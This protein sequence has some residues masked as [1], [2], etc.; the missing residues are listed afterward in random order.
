MPPKPEPPKFN[1]KDR[2]NWTEIA[3]KPVAEA[4]PV[5]RKALEDE[6]PEVQK[7]AA[8]ALANSGPPAAPAV[9]ELARALA[10][11]RDTE[12][13]RNAAVALALILRPPDGEAARRNPSFLP[14][15]R[16]HAPEAVPALVQCLKPTEPAEVRLY[17]A[18]ALA[19]IHYPAN[20]K[21]LPALLE[22]L[23][24][25]ADPQV[26][27]RCVWALYHVPD[28]KAVNAEKPLLEVL[29][30]TAPEAV[31]VRFDAA[32]VLAHALRE[33]APDRVT[34]LLLEMLTN[35]FLKVYVQTDAT[36]SGTGNEATR[37]EAAVKEK[38]AGD[39]RRLGAEALG[40]LGRKVAK[41]QKV[42]DAL[43]EANRDPDPLL[44]Q[45]AEQALKTLAA[46]G[47]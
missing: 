15:I 33:N 45:A 30:E 31:L 23:R 39:G 32:R 38:L 24:G 14:L 5:L 37:G 13:R 7:L 10:P 8:A 19:Q 36:V 35:K 20:E 6:D 40:W 21:A 4:L 43:K 3:S 34:E 47:K 9:P 26:R 25:N 1:N 11:A 28:L 16:A 17:A 27:L 44:R 18:E 2:Y 12:V 46:A 29:N 41:N 42:L 22:I